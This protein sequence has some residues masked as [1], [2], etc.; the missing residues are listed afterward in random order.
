MRNIGIISD[1][2]GL[3]RASAL[4]ALSSCDLIIHAG[5]VGKEEILDELGAIAPVAAVRG[6][7]DRGSVAEK[8]PD[9][10]VLELEGCKLLVLHDL[11]ELEL[12]PQEAGYKAVIFGH[13]H[14]PLIETRHGVLY[15][16]PGSAGPRRFRLPVTIGRLTVGGADVS[17]RIIDVG[18]Q[19][20]MSG[21]SANRLFHAV[22]RAAR[23]VQGAGARTSDAA[24]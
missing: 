12:D 8:L 22:T 4:A 5:D 19:G 23:G 6:N 20:E 16:N 11:A 18:E 17:A 14:R 15:F 1:T 2:H 10:Q 24:R 3:L 7:I 13:S 21:G 9:R